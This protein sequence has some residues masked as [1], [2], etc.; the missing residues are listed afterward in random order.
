MKIKN[1]SAHESQ[2]HGTNLAWFGVDFSED[3]YIEC[4]Y[5]AINCITRIP[6]DVWCE[7]DIPKKPHIAGLSEEE[8]DPK[9]YRDFMRSLG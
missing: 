6:E 4:G 8:I 5:S 2:L 3:F 7:Q 9:A 1:F